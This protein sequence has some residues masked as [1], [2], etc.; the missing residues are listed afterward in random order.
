MGDQATA[1]VTEI[2]TPAD[3]TKEMAPTGAATTSDR[4]D[5]AVEVLAIRE[6]TVALAAMAGFTQ[7]SHSNRH[8]HQL[9]PRKVDETAQSANA[10]THRPQDRD[11]EMK[12]P[13]GD[14]RASQRIGPETVCGLRTAVVEK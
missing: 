12:P 8:S 4:T 1:T 9:L 13:I 2:P 7:S 11:H 5:T 10:S 14:I 3:M 6:E